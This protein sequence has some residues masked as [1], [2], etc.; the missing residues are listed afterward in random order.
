MPANEHEQLD[1]G[2]T[3]KN[4]TLVSRNMKIGTP[5]ET[6]KKTIIVLHGIGTDED[7][8]VPLVEY[9]NVPGNYYFLRG[10]FRYGPNGFAY[11]E[12]NFTPQGP[13][14]N[15]KQAK[16]SLM[17]IEEWINEKKS[18]GEIASS[19]EIIF[20]GF[21]QGAIMSYAMAFSR[22]DLV[23]KVVGLNGRVL[24]EIEA[25]KPTD[26]SKKIKINALYGLN[27]EIQPIHFGHEARD[28]FQKDWIELNYKEG[29]CAHEITEESAAFAR[30]ALMS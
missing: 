15:Q 22:P 17:K 10:P 12:V 1:K 7:N 26:P 25:K 29:A 30:H 13:V 2:H 6:D 14:H 11:F 9:L 18:T 4:Y 3:V 24:K 5:V 21:S 19:S 16:Q 27:D 8:L 28:R 23:D 20:M